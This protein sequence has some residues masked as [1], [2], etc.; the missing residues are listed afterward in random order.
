[1]NHAE[2]RDSLYRILCNERVS[3]DKQVDMLYDFVDARIQMAEQSNRKLRQALKDIHELSKDWPQW[4]SHD[5]HEECESIAGRA[6][7]GLEESQ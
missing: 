3:I 2:I 1:M 6:L 5:L 4:S 7:A